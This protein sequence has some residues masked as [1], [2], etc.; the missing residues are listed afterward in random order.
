VQTARIPALDGLRGLAITLVLFYHTVFLM[1]GGF[2]FRRFQWLR[3]AGLGWSGVDL[4]FVLS[5]FLIGGILIDVSDSKG[6]FKPFYMLR[7]YRILPLYV[8]LL[9]II[10]LSSLLHL[11]IAQNGIPAVY[12]ASL[13]QNFWMAIHGEFGSIAL[14]VTWSLAIEEQFYVTLPVI[15]RFVSRPA[16]VVIACAAVIAAPLIRGMLLSRGNAFATYVLLPCRIDALALGVLAAL[17][18]REQ[19]VWRW[20]QK[21][22]AWLGAPLFLFGITIFV[23]V[24]PY[25]AIGGNTLRYSLFAFFYFVLLLLV[26]ADNRLGGAFSWAPLRYAGTIAYGLYLFHFPLIHEA[27]N[28]TF[29]LPIRALIGISLTLGLAS[30]SWFYFETPLVRRGHRYSYGPQR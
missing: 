10:R 2:R 6:Y 8:A 1:A 23:A 21:H 30:L 28:T 29:R 25:T 16:L 19:P 18:Q 22:A 27:M 17:I 3:F 26:I 11:P 5:G 24:D 14:G 20:V 7:I 4:F 9:L 13:T 12:Y 15:I